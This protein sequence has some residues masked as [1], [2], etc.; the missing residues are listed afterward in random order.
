VGTGWLLG[1]FEWEYNDGGNY[2]GT[3]IKRQEL[4]V[5]VDVWHAVDFKHPLDGLPLFPPQKPDDG[6]CRVS[7]HEQNGLVQSGYYVVGHGSMDRTV[8]PSVSAAIHNLAGA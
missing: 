5:L 3:Y 7:A 2:G 4:T 8:Y 1:K 6:L